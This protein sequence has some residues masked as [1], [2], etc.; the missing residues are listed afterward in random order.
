MVIFNHTG[1][2]GYMLFASREESPLYFLYMGCSVLCKIAVPLFF[3][4]SG[5]LLLSKEE[6][7]KQLFFKRILRMTV[8]LILASVPYYIWL[9][10]SQGMHITDFFT[11]IY[12]NCASTSLWYLYSYIGLLMLLPFL[13]SMVKGMKPRDYVY[14]FIGYIVFVGVLP[15]LEYC[16]WGDNV[17]LNPS[18]SATLFVTQN[19]FFALIGYYIEHV[20]DEKYYTGRTA[21]LWVALS[22]AAVVVTCFMTYYQAQR[23]EILTTDQQE[24]FFNAFI[25]IPA[26]TVYFISKLYCSRHS[27]PKGHK[28]LSVIGSSVFGVYL[29]EKIIRALTTSVYGLLL[30]YLGSFM[31]ST[32]WC[33]VTG[34]VAFLII[35]LLKNIPILKRI[36]NMFI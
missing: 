33:L 17:T 5:A 32:I 35:V 36:V 4:I 30:P 15:C 26:M 6:S 8:V 1:D 24:R 11:F 2:R 27:M 10:R 29:I 34:C 12:S 25:C 31:T 22:L 16:L 7:F 28:A 18:F 19:V 20:M 9:H 14:L 3:M 13:R 21:L 23:T